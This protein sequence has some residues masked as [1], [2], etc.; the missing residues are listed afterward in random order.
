MAEGHIGKILGGRYRIDSLIESTELAELYRGTN[1]TVD[2]EVTIKVVSPRLSDFKNEIFEEARKISRIS[3]PNVLSVMDLGEDSDGTVF[4]VYEAFEGSSLS[5][6]VRNEGQFTVERSINIVRQ[7][8]AA[9]IAV[10]PTRDVHGSL[11]PENIVLGSAGETAKV[12]NFFRPDTFNRPNRDALF[13]PSVEDANYFAPELILG[14]AADERSDV[15][16]LGVLL[17]RTLTGEIPFA[18]ASMPEVVGKINNDPPPPMSSFRTDLPAD[19]ERVILTAMAKNPEMRYQ[20]VAEFS[21]ELAKFASGSNVVA[22]APTGSSAHDIWK[23]AF[24]VLAAVS[25][26]TVALIYATSVKSNEPTTQLQADANGQPVQ[27]IG[28]ATGVAEQNLASMQ[29]PS[30][31][32]M[33]NSNMALPPGTLPGGDGYDPWKNGGKPP[34]GAPSGGQ[35]VTIDPNNPSPFMTNDGPCIPQPSGIVLCPAPV[36][37]AVKPTPTPR[38][39]AA[40]ANVAPKTTPTPDAKPTPAVTKTPVKPAPT[41]KPGQSGKPRNGDDL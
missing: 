12:L 7:T 19:L 30:A 41:P 22:A 14:T 6:A 31:D 18:A 8:A 33:S 24:V 23:T 34:P 25:L 21:E 37:R 16:T 2:R 38:P 36:N 39:S 15:Y 26:L 10:A 9:L 27:P 13:V 5:S 11:K 40:N 35:V 1:T 29:D 32:P 17:F 28:P 3:H 20:M 4:V